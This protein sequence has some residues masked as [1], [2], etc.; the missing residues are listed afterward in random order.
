M[1][2]LFKMTGGWGGVNELDVYF[3]NSVALYGLE[4]EFFSY[5]I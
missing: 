4:I 2:L 3:S 5:S 1:S